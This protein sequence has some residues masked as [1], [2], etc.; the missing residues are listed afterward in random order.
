YEAQGK[1]TEADGMGSI[2][3]VA[4]AIDEALA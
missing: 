2:E 1:L 3:S 4:R